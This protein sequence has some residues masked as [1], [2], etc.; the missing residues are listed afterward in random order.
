MDYKIH[1]TTYGEC[2]DEISKMYYGTEKMMHVLL[3]E[4]PKYKDFEKLPANAKIK[5]PILDKPL[6][7]EELPL[8]KK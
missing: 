7:N 1:I 6:S 8:W 3:K 5:I 4:N 2:W